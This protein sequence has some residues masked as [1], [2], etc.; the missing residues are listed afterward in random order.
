METLKGFIEKIE[1]GEAKVLTV[2]AAKELK[3]KRIAYLFFGYA[4]NQNEVRETTVGN[5]VSSFDYEKTQPFEGFASR[6][7]QWITFMTKKQVK[8][9]Q[10]KLLLLDENDKYTSYICCYGG[11]YSFF[12]EPTFTCSD[13]DREVYYLV[14][15]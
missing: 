7:D 5:I 12:P 8:E 13:V 1:S 9:Q 11:K 14:L 15:N 6:A 2:E 3:G 10:E 4:G